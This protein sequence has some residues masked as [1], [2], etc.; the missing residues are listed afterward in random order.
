[1]RAMTMAKGP[2]RPSYHD[3]QAPE[4]FRAGIALRRSYLTGPANTPEEAAMASL[5][6]GVEQPEKTLLHFGPLPP[7]KR[8]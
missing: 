8:D 7:L 4:L 5:I 3:I 2:R 1:M 6:E